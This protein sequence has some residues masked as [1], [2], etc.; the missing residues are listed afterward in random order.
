[1]DKD[2]GKCCSGSSALAVEVPASPAAGTVC[3]GPSRWPRRL[4][5]ALLRVGVS[6][7]R[8]EVQQSSSLQPYVMA[9]GAVCGFSGFVV[10]SAFTGALF[11]MHLGLQGLAG[12]FV[13]G[14]AFG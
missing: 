7:R 8:G 12:G 14:A 2:L 10:F 11:R 6:S 4:V 3:E 5:S 13:F 1:V 9:G